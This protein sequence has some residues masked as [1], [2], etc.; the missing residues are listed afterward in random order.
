MAKLIDRLGIAQQMAAK[1]KLTAL[2]ARLKKGEIAD[3]AIVSDRQFLP[4]SGNRSDLPHHLQHVGRERVS[5]P[6]GFLPKARRP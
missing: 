4:I 3:V 2:T 5:R 1:T 6:V